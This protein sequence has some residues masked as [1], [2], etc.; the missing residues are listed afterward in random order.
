MIYVLDVEYHTGDGFFGA[1]NEFEDKKDAIR[2]LYN[3][4]KT[5]IIDIA[6]IFEVGKRESVDGFSWEELQDILWCLEQVEIGDS[7][8]S[9]E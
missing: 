7:S 9:K 4:S 1:I 2:Y 3:L 5:G 6:E 8:A